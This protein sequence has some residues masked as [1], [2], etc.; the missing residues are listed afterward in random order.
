MNTIDAKD[1]IMSHKGSMKL[2]GI[3]LLE[4]KELQCKSS[5]NQ[6]TLNTMNSSSEIERTVSYKNEITFKINKVS[7]R[8]KKK[9]LDNA[10]ELKETVYDVEFWAENDDGEQEYYTIKSAWFKGD[11]N[12]SSLNSNGDFTEESY[13]MGFLIENM[14][15]PN[16][17]TTSDDDW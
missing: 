15:M 7:T 12:W 9:L 6:K 11:I 16:Q 17:I 2:N 8:F 14:D 3:E 1:Y 5:P 13:T 4:L 10:K